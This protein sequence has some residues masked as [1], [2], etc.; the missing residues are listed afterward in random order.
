MRP[1]GRPSAACE[2]VFHCGAFFTGA[3]ANPNASANQRV[4]A[5]WHAWWFINFARIKSRDGGIQSPGR[6]CARGALYEKSSRAPATLARYPFAKLRV[7]ARVLFVAASA[8]ARAIPDENA[9]RSARRTPRGEVCRVG[10]ISRN[11]CLNLIN[12]SC[13]LILGFADYS[14]YSLILKRGMKER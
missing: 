9:P 6:W 1:L 3:A 8:R 10:A 13:N 5:A 11:F 4:R 2:C 12:I 7:I 14:R